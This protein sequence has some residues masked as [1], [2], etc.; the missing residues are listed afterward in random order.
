MEPIKPPLFSI[1]TPTYNAADV[2]ASTLSSVE[3]Q[4]E[5]NYEYILIDGASTD[6]TVSR[7]KASGIKSMR[8]VCE[9]D[10]GLYDAMNKGIGMARGEYL[11]FLNAGDALSDDNVL[12]RL[13][14]KVATGNY[15]I[16]YGQTQ[17]VDKKGKV[18]GKRHLSAPENLT[19]DSFRKGMLVC[20]QAFVAR[21]TIVPQYDLSYR[22]SS[23]YD[24]CIRCLQRS[25]C[26]GYVGARPII[27]YLTAAD[28]VTVSNHRAS[29]KERFRI[30]CHYYGTFST[31]LYHLSFILR[32][33][34]E[35]RCRK[36]Y[37]NDSEN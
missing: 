7:V 6:E 23:D 9:P 4:S 3:C 20:H 37:A 28:G 17:L 25:H 22:F 14:S 15:D 5:S 30:M 36:K 21:R 12:A 10:H 27:N 34:K 19:V 29:L 24:W 8:I 35:K 16:L 1:I 31:I 32:Y 2:I 18:V 13:A 11:I 33:L 26:N